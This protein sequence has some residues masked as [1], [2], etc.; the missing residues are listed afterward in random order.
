M[1]DQLTLTQLRVQGVLDADGSDTPTSTPL[2]VDLELHLDLETA[3]RTDDA[4]QSIDISQVATIV[5]AVA[6]D[7]HWALLESLGLAIARTLLLPPAPGETRTRLEA[8]TLRLR[9][10]AWMRGHATPGVVLHRTRRWCTTERRVLGPGV[11]ADVIAE[12]RYLDLLRVR[13]TGGARWTPPAGA[14]VVILGEA[15]LDPTD[16]HALATPRVLLVVHR[17]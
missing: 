11:A 1:H 12:T 10:P 16:A 13:L 9:R 7:G 6:G 17:K 15:S 8:V 3:G 2:D 14:R 4:G 5:E